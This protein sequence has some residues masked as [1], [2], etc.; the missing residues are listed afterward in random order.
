MYLTLIYTNTYLILVTEILFPF[1]SGIPLNL[2]I[3]INSIRRVN[4]LLNY[5][6]NL[7]SAIQKTKDSNRAPNQTKY[8]Y[9]QLN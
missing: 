7:N 2:K 6:Q 5:I 9:L 8:F 1:N 4:I 3:N